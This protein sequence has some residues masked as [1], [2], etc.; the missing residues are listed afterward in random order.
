MIICFLI[1]TLVFII[2]LYN[3]L[4]KIQL[5]HNYTLKI[6]DE[7]NDVSVYIYTPN[8]YNSTSPLF[9]V[10][11]G[12]ER[13]AQKYLKYFTNLAEKYNA[14]I[15]AP[16]FQAYKYG[17][18]GSS[19]SKWSFKNATILFDKI[20]NMFN[21]PKFALIG[22]SGGAQFVTRYISIESEFSKYATAIIAANA[23][24]YAFPY[25]HLNWPYG[26]NDVDPVIFT[27]PLTLYLGR[28]DIYRSKVLDKSQQAES[29]GENRLLRGRN[30]Y[31]HI[32]NV[33][34]ETVWKKV[35]VDGIGH[36]ANK[37]FNNPKMFQILNQYFTTQTMV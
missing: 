16:E 29:E 7:V 23:G 1:F 36:N 3:L 18:G 28:N 22:H 10:I 20:L 30:Y 25:S 19:K 33:A 9:F 13:G 11:H 12:A 21:N 17:S 2:S 5:S 8:N 15:V 31:N 34:P 35:E 4:Y 26:I 14:I 24:S 37:M 6:F 27:F 32:L